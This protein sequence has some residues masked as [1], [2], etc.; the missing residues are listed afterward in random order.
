VNTSVVGCI[1]AGGAS[2][3]MGRGKAL[4]HVGGKPVTQRVA[5]VMRDV[6]SHLVISTNTPQD[7]AFLGLPAV[8]DIFPGCGPMGGIHAALSTSNADT[9]FVVGCD[10]PFLRAE[11]LRDLLDAHPD[12]PIVVPWHDGRLHPLCGVYRRET[13]PLMEA[14]LRNGNFKLIDFIERT[15]GTSVP[16]TSDLPFY[17]PHL[18]HNI[19]SPEDLALAEE[20]ALLERH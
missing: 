8:A 9:V 4:L 7:F 12:S 20:L 18:F 5:D 15:G 3:R 11:L 19:N 17:L 14:A 13:L 16:I 10:M 1:L 2:S 6:F